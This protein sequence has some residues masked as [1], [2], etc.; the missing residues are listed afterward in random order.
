MNAII[1][2]DNPHK[3]INGTMFYCFEYYVFLKQYCP[4]L[5]FI[6]LSSSQPTVDYFKEIFI[7]KYQFDMALLDDVIPLNRI[8]LMSSVIKCVIMFDVRSYI[9]AKDY[10][11]RASKVLLYCNKEEG[12]PYLNYRSNHTFYG[13]YDSYQAYNVKNRLKLYPA[14]HKIFLDR[15]GNKTLVSSPNGDNAAI[16]NMLGL[17]MDNVLIKKPKVHFTGLFERI[18]KIVYYHVG[19]NDA[20]NR[21]IVEAAIHDMDI[22]VHINGHESDSVYDRYNVIK[23]GNVSELL[24]TEDDR[25]VQDFLEIANG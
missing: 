12:M 11:G 2:L 6:H 24:L 14:I 3:P 8:Q 10:L 18:N 5:K 7:D 13:W 16:A 15:P 25:M 17:D 23:S 1:Y 19:K 22:D 20:N 9:E 21:I 4:D